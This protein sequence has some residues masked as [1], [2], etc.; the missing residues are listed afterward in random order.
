MF[1]HKRRRIVRTTISAFVVALALAPWSPFSF[2]IT[3]LAHAAATVSANTFGLINGQFPGAPI[4]ASSNPQAIVK[5][6]VTASAVSKTLNSVTVN[7]AGTGFATTDLA[8]IG[9]ATSSG[10]AL[11]IDNGSSVDAFDTTDNVVELASSPDWTSVSPASITLTPATPV[12]LTNGVEKIFYVAIRTS[13]TVTNDDRIAATIPASGVVT[14]D[15]NGPS[16]SFTAND[17]RA[18]T[19]A[20]TIAAV[21]SYPGQA[22]LSVKFSEPVQKVGGGNIAAGDNPFTYTDGGGSAQTI[23]SMSH[24]MGQIMVGL[25]MSGNLDAQDFSAPGTMAAASNKIADMAGNVAGTSAVNLTSPPGI[26]TSNIPSATAGT[27]YASGAPLATLVVAG[28]AGTPVWGMANAS[29]TATMSAL[30]LAINSSTAK[31]TGTVNNVSGSFFVMFEAGDGIATTTRGYPINVAPSGGGGVPGITAVNPPGGL[32]NTT[33]FILSITGANTHFTNS[34]V[35]EVLLPPGGAGTNGITV[36]A[37]S[38][39]GAT[40]LTASVSVANNATAGQRDIKVTTGGETVILSNGFS[41]GTSGG[42]GLNLNF[43]LENGTNVSLPPGFSFSQSANNTVVSYRIT[44][45]SS[46]DLNGNL[47]PLWDYAF[48]KTTDG[49]GHCN[50]SQCNLPY[51]AGLYRI[52]T[53][54]TMLNANTDYYWQI[55]S[56][57]TS[58]QALIESTVPVESTPQRKFTTVAS[59]TDTTPPNIFHRPVFRATASTDLDVFARVLDNVAN[60]S[61]TP[62]LATSIFYC[63]GADCSPTTQVNGVTLANGYYKY[64]IPSGTIS[65]AGTI[66]RY[67][68]RASDGTNTFNFK[69]PDGSTPFQLTSAAAGASSIAGSVK[70]SADTCASAVQGATV[71]AEGTGFSATTNGSCAFTLS[72]LF[73]GLYDIVA[74]KPGYADRKID[75]VA[76]GATGIALKL[77]A[78]GGGG[79][80]GDTN[81]PQVKFTGPMDGM[82]NMPGG[83]SDFKVFIVFNKNMS[84]NSI[85]TPGNLTVKSLNVGTGVLT[86]VTASGTWTFY[87]TAPQIQMLPPEAN[88]AVW[89]LNNPNILGDDKTFVVSV[90]AD[91]TD[92]ASNSIQG[93]Q[94]DGSYAFSF[95]T[96]KAF[97]GSFGGGQFGQ[98]AFNPPHVNGTT[99]PPGMASVPLNSKIIINFSDPMADDS[100]GYVLKSFVK[101]YRV[102]NGTETDISSSAIDTV[103]LDSGKL[104]AKLSLLGS[105]NSGLFESNTKYRIKILGGAKSASGLTIAPPDQPSQVMYM[106][107]FTTGSTSDTAAPTIVGSFPDNGASG[108]PVNMGV[109]NVGFDKDMDGSTITTNSVYLSIGSTAINGTVSYKPLERQVIFIPKTALTPNTTY[110]LNVTTDVKAVNGVALASASTRTFTTGAADTDAPKIGFINSDEFTLAI[111]LS[112]AVSAVKAVDT[113]NYPNSILNPSTYNVIKYGA[114]GFN[115]GSAGTAVSLSSVTFTYDQTS[116]TV[117]ISGLNLPSAAIGQELYVSFQTAGDNVLKDLSGNAMG[118]SG[119]SARVTIKNSQTTKGQLG[120]NAMTGDMFSSGG[121][122][123][124]TNFSAS[125]FGFAP[126]VEARPFN[127]MAGQS[128]I[129]HLSL[130]ISKQIPAGGTIILTLPTGFDVTS[131]KQDINSPMRTDLNGPGTGAVTFKCET[132]VVGGKSCAGG[133]ANADDTGAAQGGLADDGVVVN[134]SARS[135]TVYVSTA[136]NSAGHDFINLDIGGIKNSTV[137]K[138]FNT[139]GYTI[140]IKTLNGST[141]LESLTSSPFFLQSAGTR[142]L[143]GTI[144]ATANDQSGTA[145]VYLMSPMTGPLE[146]TSANFSGGATASYTFSNIPSGEFMLFTDQSITLGSKEFAGK[147]NPERVVVS[148]GAVTTTY[149]FTLNSN[150]SGGTNVT[151]NVTGPASE[152]LDVFAGS[153]VGF[154]VKQITLNGGGTGSAVLNLADGEWFLGVGPQMPKGPGGGAPPTPSYL[155]PKPKSVRIG[156]STCAIEGT[157]GCTTSVTLSTSSK[158]IKGTVQD[159]SGKVMADAEVYAYSPTGGV[160]TRGSTDATGAFTLNVAEGSYVVGSFVQGMPPSK[161]VPVN[162]SSAVSSY[163]FIDGSVTGVSPA[164]AASTFILKVAK[165]DYTISGKVTDGTNVVQGASVY[166]YRTDGP[167]RANS[168]TDSKGAY[169]LYTTNGTWKVG[170]F[171]P[172]Y[173]N[174]SEQTVTVS[175]SSQSNINFSPS[176]TGTF[177]AVSGRVYRDANSNASYDNGEAIQGAFVRLRGNSTNNEAISGSDGSYSFNIPSGNGYTITGFAPG[178]GELAP[179][180]AFNVSGAVTNKDLVIT[181]SLNT[182]TIVFSTTTADAFIEIVSST[183]QGAR[184]SVKN[185]TSTTLSLPNGQYKLS[186]FSAGS[187]LGISDATGTTNGTG[188]NQTTGILTIDGNESITI[189]LPNLRSVTGT[190]TSGG[191]AITDA[192]VEISQ[193]GSNIHLGAR[194]GNDGTFTLQVADSAT[195]YVLNAMKSGYV[196]EPI[197]ITVNGSN[198]GGQTLTMTAA[199]LSISGQIKIGSSGAANAFVRAEK[200]GGGFAGTQADANGNYTLYVTPGSWRVFAVGEGYAEAGLSSN[201]VTMSESSVS[202]KNITLTSTVTLD[203]PK[204]KPITPSSGGTLEDTTAGVKLTVPA[205][206]LGTQTSAGNIEAKETNNVR[207]TAAAKPVAGEAVE[208]KA[209]DASG[210]PITN[211]N[212]S[213]TIELSYTKAELATTESASDSSINTKAEVDKLQ[214]AYWDETTQAWVTLASSITYKDSDGNVVISPASDLSNVSTVTVAAPTTHFS[215]YAPI[216]ST[217]S[218][219]PSTP[220]GLGATPASASSITLSWT[221]VNAATSYDLYRS[222]SA[223]GTYSRLGSEPTVSSSSTVSYTDSSLSSNTLYYYKISSLNGNGESAA[224]SNVSART[225]DAGGGGGGGGSSVPLTQTFQISVQGATGTTVITQSPSSTTPAANPA[226]TQ[227]TTPAPASVPSTPIVALPAPKVNTLL[228]FL[229]APVKKVFQAKQKVSFSYQFKN[230]GKGAQPIYIVRQIL[231]PNGKV[232]SSAKANAA[233][234]AGKTFDGKVSVTLPVKSAEGIY[235]VWVRIFDQ[236]NKSK[237]LSQESFTFSVSSGKSTTPSNASPSSKPAQKKTYWRLGQ[238]SNSAHISFIGLPKSVVLPKSFAFKYQLLLPERMNVELMRQLLKGEAM[239]SESVGSRSVIGNKPL[240]ISASQAMTSLK[241][242]TY[243][244]VVLMVVDGEI[245]EASFAF[246]IVEE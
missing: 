171:I 230:N 10:V 209:T 135:V 88:M 141:L 198:V 136:T 169:T 46:Q 148:S 158:T 7:F 165:P 174:L 123:V 229:N 1:F 223:D 144:T 69:Q 225:N 85:T 22:G 131:A 30:G 242:G 162:V 155:M 160:G 68:L 238:V 121:G 157:S 87:P 45:K 199:S 122:F 214:M 195:S 173:G 74:V 17:Y 102:S 237:V 96:G 16:S 19:V 181:G 54:P 205:N 233:V 163:L 84:Q 42:A 129:Y 243:K 20:P 219:A 125:T 27:T 58:S 153:P 38:S 149:N 168:I 190:V 26:T 228:R 51:G 108:V 236:K 215:L 114:V 156:S 61:T 18:D 70:D 179:L 176:Q 67:Y 193:P 192:W 41:V 112:E 62:A 126:P 197:S 101:L 66:V 213:V 227:V 113:V 100:G 47:T 76:Q 71:F 55:R 224:S 104:T 99:P 94:P 188:Y 34:S 40:A 105:F 152:P 203:P 138:D 53:Q 142:D 191:S 31:I 12:A 231:D 75:G 246:E 194:S 204:T 212:D 24:N 8:T 29:S 23:S 240:M 50:V 206:A 73:S 124:P 80:G 65:S 210:N 201:P 202:G 154:R 77:S 63:Q 35:V 235:T 143:T 3:P 60:T 183:N 216:V 90:S 134:T 117:T 82:T 11:Y 37:A 244:M 178:V 56:Y 103:T 186:Q 92:S 106:S 57:S 86:N 147:S 15:G 150:T 32:Q 118:S 151:V 111:T 159:A 79:G 177:Y 93:N 161:E 218:N 180:A 200:Q 184:V 187:S 167:G 139:S 164:T 245:E 116:N 196:R 89:A 78:G 232:V 127:T 97:T 6:K 39:S 107:D 110:T 211:F 95:S 33:N 59:I 91:V 239:I 217:D 83:F 182:V 185:V 146:T 222:T 4:K 2:L 120:P 170:S 166:A 145:K 130:P 241:P 36:N 13:G 115:P 234:K 119:S 52:M 72:G 9:T 128:T 132:N 98:G 140:D 175:G 14:S 5:I 64:T 207:E 220:S 44:V 81:R 49:S 109:V 137:P 208:F 133:A 226:T 48:Q 221:G 25:T 43:P 172:Q 21:E 189:T 28:L